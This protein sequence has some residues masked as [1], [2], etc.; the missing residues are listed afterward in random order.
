MQKRF[1]FELGRIEIKLLDFLYDHKHIFFFVILTIIALLLR[2]DLRYFKSGDYV[3]FLEPWGEFLEQNGGFKGIATLESNYNVAYLYILAFLTY[4]PT[5][6]LA[7]IKVVNF[8]FEFA[9][10]FFVMLIIRDIFNLNKKSL[11]PYLGYALILFAPTVILNGAV[12]GQ[13]DIIYTCFIVCSLY[14]LIRKKY[15]LSF[16]SYGIALAFKLQALFFLPVLLLFYIKER[17]FSGINFLLLPLVNFLIYV[18]AWI[19]GKPIS[20]LFSAYSGQ[21]VQY[22]DLVLN[23]SNIYSILPNNYDFFF[24]SGILISIAV[25]CGF[26][27]ILLSTKIK[28]RPCDYITLAMITVMICTYFLPSMHERYMFTADILAIIYLFL[29]PKHYFVTLIIWFISVNTYLPY[30]YG[31]GPIIDYRIMSLVYLA[32]LVFLIIDLLR[33]TL[34]TRTA[35]VS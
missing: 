14:F 11:I 7:K 2:N 33:A 20:D 12:W 35:L 17:R 18:P 22:K 8:I 30:L 31:F 26:Y 34:K 24:R 9:T 13:C 28:L 4:L 32:L 25:L 16:I 15:S 6:L 19:L 23:F 1:K 27:L 3:H 10:A 5:Y 29:A 21:V